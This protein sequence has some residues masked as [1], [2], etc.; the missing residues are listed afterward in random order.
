MKTTTPTTTYQPE[1][2]TF[3]PIDLYDLGYYEGDWE[4]FCDRLDLYEE[5]RYF[6]EHELR[7]IRIVVCQRVLEE[8]KFDKET[9]AACA[10][11]KYALTVSCTGFTHPKT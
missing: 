1:T 4:K 11:Y 6:P 10:L 5:F 9:M 3:I 2:T 8:K 7:K